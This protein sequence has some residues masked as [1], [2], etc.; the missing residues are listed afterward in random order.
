M[1][2]V[3]ESETLNLVILIPPRHFFC[4]ICMCYLVLRINLH[5]STY[6]R[7]GLNIISGSEDHYI[8]VWKTHHDV[9]KLT[10]VRRDR[11]EFYESFSSTILLNNILLFVLQC[12]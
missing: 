9:N 3:L 1:Q 10:S 4:T 2:P 7:D 5:A 8:Y 6:S 12:W 11:N